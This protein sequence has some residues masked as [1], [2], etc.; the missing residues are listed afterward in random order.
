MLHASRPIQSNDE[1]VPET[2]REL[3]Q[4]KTAEAAETQFNEKVSA[5]SKVGFFGN[6]APDSA[7]KQIP[8]AEP[9]ADNF[10]HVRAACL[11]LVDQG[12]L[13]ETAQKQNWYIRRRVAKVRAIVDREDL[14]RNASKDALASG[15]DSGGM[16]QEEIALAREKN[17]YQALGELVEDASDENIESARDVLDVRIA[18]RD[19]YYSK[20]D[21][22]K[23]SA[24]VQLLNCLAATV[25]PLTILGLPPLDEEI[26]K[27][28]MPAYIQRV[29][30]FLYIATNGAKPVEPDS[31]V[32]VREQGTDQLKNIQE[33]RDRGNAVAAH[34]DH[35]KAV[36]I[37]AKL[38]L[39]SA[40]AK[41]R[42]VA[43]DSAE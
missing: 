33:L 39:D 40:E 22:I 21:A 10:P 18:E 2:A 42:G 24:Q 41:Y 11:P 35:P 30:Q 17:D 37:L 31:I 12:R 29:A 38:A 16:E 15:A 27:S 14:I 7:R 19:K 3:M 5:V 36:M 23:A 34:L 13:P 6:A 9:A 8:E 28:G 20:A 26:H 25:A 43:I 1:E 4:R 32:A